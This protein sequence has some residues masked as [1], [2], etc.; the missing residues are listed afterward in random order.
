MNKCTCEII[1]YWKLW[2]YLCCGCVRRKRRGDRAE[3]RTEKGE[4]K[5]DTVQ[6]W[7]QM[8]RLNIAGQPQER[9]NQVNCF[10]FCQA[11][12]PVNEE[13]KGMKMQH[14]LFSRTE[15]SCDMRALVLLLGLSTSCVAQIPKKCCTIQVQYKG[16]F[17]I[18]YFYVLQGGLYAAFFSTVSSVSKWSEVG[19][20]TKLIS[21]Y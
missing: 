19:R 12:K 15:R 17:L 1:K 20:M 8:M 14:I 4:S 13:I 11:L 18:I 9:K 2:W 10:F 21:Q 7:C 16:T 3:G 5:I 6:F